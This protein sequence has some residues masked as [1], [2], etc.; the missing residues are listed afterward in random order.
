[1]AAAQI[2][3]HLRKH[4]VNGANQPLQNSID[5]EAGMFAASQNVYNCVLIGQIGSSLALTESC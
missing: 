1:M 5:A 4:G 3:K 2:S